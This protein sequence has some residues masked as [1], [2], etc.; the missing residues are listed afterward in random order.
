VEL[1][2]L[3]K[4]SKEELAKKKAANAAASQKAG[5]TFKK[6]NMPE[7]LVKNLRSWGVKSLDELVKVNTANKKFAYLGKEEIAKVKQLKEDVDVCVLMSKIFGKSVKSLNYFKDNVEFT[8][9]AFG[10]SSG[11]EGYEWIP[12]MVADSYI[13]EFNL[14]RKIAGLFMEVKMPSNPY[15]WPVLSNGAI[16]RKVAV[17]SAIGKQTF[18]TD[19]TIQFDAQKLAGRYELP[20][21]LTED[22]APDVIKAIRI[23]LMEGQEKAV[24]IAILEGNTA[25]TL[26]HFSQLPDVVATTTIA[27]IAAETPETAFN[28]IRSRLVAATLAKSG[29]DCAAAVVSETELNKARGLM[30]KF[31]VDP[32]QIVIITGPKVYNQMLNLADVRTLDKYGPQATVLSG[33]LAKYDGAPVIVS[34]YLRE[35][36]GAAAVNTST[37]ANNIKG[38]VL[39]VNRKRWFTGLRRAIQIKVEANKTEFDVLDLVSFS[40][41]AFQAVLKA[42][43]SNYAAESSAAMVYNIGSL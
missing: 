28:G 18:D 43:G 37:P 32:S 40:R 33:E 19:N 36:L 26:H 15:K 5:T 3:L 11:N 35:D 25:G 7:T 2:E 27:S 14:E 17:A 13:D 1:R 31:A 6:S 41:K 24:E 42:D 30:G 23:E 10:I 20:E 12:T 21:E 34:E 8:L 16:A 9:K 38:S 39:F 29:V 22:S 4:K